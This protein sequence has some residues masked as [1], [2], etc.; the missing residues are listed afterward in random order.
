MA[1]T[2]ARMTPKALLAVAAL[3]ATWP[4]AAQDDTPPE[5]IEGRAVV[6]DGDTLAVDQPKGPVRV[7]LFGIDAPEMRSANGAFARAHLDELIAGA[8]VACA[9]V[10]I[11][12]YK[13]PVARCEAN[14][15]D[16]AAAMAFAGWAT[17][18]R[19][20]STDYDAQERAARDARR[21]VW[22]DLP[23]G[24]RSVSDWI[25]ELQTGLGALGGLIG[26]GLVALLNAWLTRRRDDRIRD[27]RTRAVGRVMLAEIA[28]V[29]Y[30]FKPKISLLE[31]KAAASTG[32]QR[33]FLPS[34]A[35]PTPDV[36]GSFTEIVG[37]MPDNVVEAC[38][39]YY[40]FFDGL[41]HFVEYRH[42]PDMPDTLTV[43]E[44][45]LLAKYI[46][47]TAQFAH[48]AANELRSWLGVA[49]TS[50]ADHP[51]PPLG[52]EPEF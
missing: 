28:H 21:G 20:Y 2:I 44:T 14:G 37:G 41:R 30:M 13:R 34:I 35:M 18:Y 33:T 7:R 38:A 51:D 32:V 11:D 42:R 25:V 22:R 4:A 43:P 24:G 10:E 40:M 36:F 52:E 47:Y 26:L 8:T 12:R 23:A 31:K 16:L 49:D 50:T 5:I 15:R 6:L 27:Q 17:S 9:V 3:A 29:V 19:V 48:V 1:P 45:E 39:K 46:K